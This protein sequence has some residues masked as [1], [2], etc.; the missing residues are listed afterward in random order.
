MTVLCDDRD[1]PGV[2]VVVDSHADGCY[3]KMANLKILIFVFVDWREFAL[4]VVSATFSFV[5]DSLCL[6]CLGGLPMKVVV[7]DFGC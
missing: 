2:V 7:V 3:L 4:G 5:P 6:I 1:C